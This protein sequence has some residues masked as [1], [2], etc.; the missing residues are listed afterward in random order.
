MPLATDRSYLRLQY[1]DGE[2]LRIR[3]EAHRLYSE[4]QDS[5]M[6]W[7][8]DRL[9]PQPGE[10]IAYVGS[11]QGAYHPLL[12]RRGA[13]IVA[14]DASL[15][16]LA[17]AA[18]EARRN[19]LSMSAV[20]ASAERL[21]LADACCD[22]LMANHMLYHVP[23]KIAALREMERVVRPGGRLVLTTNSRD[24]GARMAQI[25]A[26]AAVAVGLRA[27]TRSPIADFTLESG[28]P[29]VRSVFADVETGDAG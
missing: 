5:F 25:H 20:Q 6:E 18:G 17:E 15:G 27:D 2:K 16:M 28:A 7:V 11:G 19:A 21:P 29:L 3:Q 1:A 23:D 24:N 14:V 9:D 10:C 13:R 22:R 12:A 4:R 8:L 26:Q